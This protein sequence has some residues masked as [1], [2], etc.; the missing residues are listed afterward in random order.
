MVSVVLKG[1][2]VVRV[3]LAGGKVA[4]YHYAWKGKGA[5]R[6]T[7]AP[8]SP[9][10]VAGY[11]EAHQ[12]RKRPQT[13]SLLDV[14]AAFKASADFAKLSD[15]TKRAY[16]RHLDQI[17]VRFGD[18]PLK[19]LDDPRVRRHF[20]EWR[21][22]FAD[23]PRTADYAVGTLKR[24]L[25]WGVER[26]YFHTNQAEPVGRL[27]RAD[28]SE[29]IWTADDMAAFLAVASTELR[30]ALG[31][32]LHTGL[33][34]SDLIRLAWNNY[35]GECFTARTSKTGRRVIIP[36][37]L[38]CRALMKTID[39]RQV[40]ILT[41]TRG[42]RPW[43]ADGLRSSFGKTCAD[44]GVKRTFHD[45]RRTAA[46]G[47]LIAGIEAPKVAMIMGWSEEDVEALKRRYVSRSAVVASVLAQLEK[48][49]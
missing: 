16:R 15:H 43:T 30:W 20:L 3:R 40:V 29:D 38:A 22:T 23:H 2:H 28:K 34:Q 25:A 42:H 26:V 35:D 44:A 24:L 46:T 27:H 47:L 11:Q 17:Q 31:L 37:T 48:G 1:V 41:T 14:I 6:L 10:Y 49:G 7:G 45:L 4:E 8:G 36:A 19:A 13:G 18:M 12:G 5:P 39:K 33:R 32:A 21:D 9:E